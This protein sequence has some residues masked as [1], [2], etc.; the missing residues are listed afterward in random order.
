MATSRDLP[1]A[2]FFAASPRPTWSAAKAAQDDLAGFV[3]QMPGG[4]T[5]STLTIA[6]GVATPVADAA[7]CVLI[8]TEG[9]AAADDLTHIATTECAEGV[10][11]LLRVANAARVVTLK[12]ASGGTG[13]L[14]LQGSADLPLDV[15]S[16][17]VLFILISGTWVHIATFNA[18]W[19]ESVK[20]KTANYTVVAGQ[21]QGVT[22]SNSGA[23]GEVNLTLPAATA[24]QRYRMVV[25]TAQ[26]FRVTAG[27][28]DTIRDAATV[29]AAAGNAVNG[30]IGGVLEFTAID[31]D[32]WIV[33]TSNGTWT[34]T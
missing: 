25:A 8:D 31:G 3:K 4:A 34:Y 26:N 16:R 21:D 32:Q 22:F 23:A 33:T 14:S 5:V 29:T 30:T 13:Q 2:D 7:R 19:G 11:L 20:V 18:A 15:T 1:S 24:G 27:A 12:H 17:W 28:G 10:L 6:T 9:A